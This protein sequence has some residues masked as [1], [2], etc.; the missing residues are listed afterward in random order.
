M[1][2]TGEKSNGNIKRL[3]EMVLSNAIHFFFLSSL[4]V[5]KYLDW[6]RKRLTRWVADIPY[7]FNN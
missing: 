4:E 5:W 3:I 1:D 2:L 7:H 6:K